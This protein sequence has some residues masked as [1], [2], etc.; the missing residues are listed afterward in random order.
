MKLNYIIEGTHLN[1]RKHTL[2]SMREMMLSGESAPINL[3]LF[4]DQFFNLKNLSEEGL[5]KLNTAKSAW[6]N[7]VDDFTFFLDY[8][9]KAETIRELSN[10]EGNHK[11]GDVFYSFLSANTSIA[12]KLNKK[13]SYSD[14]QFFIN[15]D[16]TS[17]FTSK[18]ADLYI[19]KNELHEHLPQHFKTYYDDDIHSEN[20][21]LSGK[22]N[23]VIFESPFAGDIDENTEYAAKAIAKLLIHHN[24]APMASHLLYTRMLN[25]HL[26]DERNLGIDA[27]LEYGRHAEETIIGIDRGLSTGM[28][29]GVKNAIASNR[30]FSCFTMSDDPT[31]KKE[32]S[33]LDSL[34][35]I[36]LWIDSQKQ[37]NG[38][39][40]ENTG[41]VNP[42]NFLKNKENLNSSLNKIKRII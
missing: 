34:E 31:I 28:K 9:I 12:P 40:F 42:M 33:Q 4:Y 36:E 15:D 37:K 21:P 41:Y 3:D 8:G 26:E 10:I 19:S 13:M 16:S 32:V 22:M 29:Y 35:K 14:A 23:R 38:E 24:K 20:T 25:D 2:H 39:L 6:F 18:I 5:D 30:P 7:V 27:G 1:S 17:L 11:N